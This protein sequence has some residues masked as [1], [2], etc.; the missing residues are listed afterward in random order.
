MV[1][2]DGGNRTQTCV[3]PHD[4]ADTCSLLAHVQGGRLVRVTGNPNHPVTR[5][6]LC[7]KVSRYPELVYHPDRILFP[8]VRVGVKGEGRFRRVSWSEAIERIVTRWQRI[9]AHAGPRAIL[10]FCGSGNEG[11]INGHLAGRRFFNRLGS[12][13]MVRTICT[14]AGRLGYQAV[15]GTSLGA[16]PTRVA[17]AGVIIVWGANTAST[18]CTSMP[19]SVRPGAAAPAL[20]WSIRCGWGAVRA[21]SGSCVPVRARMPPWRWR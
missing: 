15:M 18:P 8:M 13:Q 7:R 10:P 12:L 4:C 16:D 19:C 9:L 5:G 20:P 14:K 6:F 3:C 21:P 2:L 1:T 11:V 17:E